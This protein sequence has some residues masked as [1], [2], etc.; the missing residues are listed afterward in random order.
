MA[1]S[2]IK[3]TAILARL[4]FLDAQPGGRAAVIAKMSEA[5]QKAIDSVVP[6]GQYPL[7]LKARLDAQ[8]AAVLRPGDPSAMFY[9]LGRWAAKQ[10]FELY[11][12]SFVTQGDPQ[13]FMAAA[14]AM[15]RLFYAEDHASYQ[16]TGD[17]TGTFTVSGA[18]TVD[19]A[20]CLGTAGYWEFAIELAG[21]KRARVAHR[22]C[23]ARGDSVCE[24]ECSWE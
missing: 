22:K 2:D 17:K 21:G 10:N 7:A 19:A 4:S 12:S 8:I 16:R 11:H 5:D 20:D 23:I 1:T 3:G 24:F 15:R 9:E 13:G 6:I 18:Q 14:P